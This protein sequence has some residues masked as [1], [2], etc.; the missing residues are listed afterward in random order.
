MAL[1][2]PRHKSLARPYFAGL[3]VNRQGLAKTNRS[4][5]YQ[6]RL[7]GSP[8]FQFAVSEPDT[9][10]AQPPPVRLERLRGP[11][12][13]VGLARVPPGLPSRPEISKVDV[14]PVR[15]K[16]RPVRIFHRDQCPPFLLTEIEKGYFVV[17][18]GN[19]RVP[20]RRKAR[21]FE[22]ARPRDGRHL[23]GPEVEDVETGLE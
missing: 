15:R 7:Q 1:P 2:S 23:V 11:G 9:K 17:V 10:D 3:G 12:F 18:V 4:V 16:G 6:R 5:G 20:I 13:R 8:V 19:H 22:F 14:P 21:E